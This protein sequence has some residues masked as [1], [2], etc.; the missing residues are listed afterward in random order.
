VVAEPPQWPKGVA[1]H[2]LLKKKKKGVKEEGCKKKKNSGECQTGNPR[3]KWETKSVHCHSL[4]QSRPM[5]AQCHLLEPISTWHQKLSKVK[6]MA[7]LL[8]GGHEYL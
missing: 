4:L 3:M 8:I 6:G 1:G 2:P 5:L 7:V